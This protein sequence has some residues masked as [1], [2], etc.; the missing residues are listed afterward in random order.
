MPLGELDE[1]LAPNASLRIEYAQNGH[2]DHYNVPG[3]LRKVVDRISIIQNGLINCYLTALHRLV[4]DVEDET[5]LMRSETLSPDQ[6]VALSNEMYDPACL[7]KKEH[8]MHDLLT[9]RSQCIDI[10]GFEAL[11]KLEKRL[12]VDSNSLSHAERSGVEKVDEQSLTTARKYL[13]DHPFGYGRTV[14]DTCETPEQADAH[15]V[16]R[17]NE[18]YTRRYNMC[19]MS[20]FGIGVMNM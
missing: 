7:A 3:N 6:A 20:P 12:R 10:Y 14:E 8:G 1:S 18:H 13:L 19:S 9:L 4:S 16:R 17:M 11:V 2:I 15:M 5:I